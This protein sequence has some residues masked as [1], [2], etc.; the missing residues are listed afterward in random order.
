[1]AGGPTS[2]I[3]DAAGSG[4]DVDHLPFGRFAPIGHPDAL[5]RVGARIGGQVLEVA[6]ALPP[7]LRPMF[8]VGSLEPFLS[9]GPDTWA[10]V[11]SI[12]I[13]QLTDPR[14]AERLRP[15]LHSIDAVS[16]LRPVEVGDYVDFYASEHHAAALGRMFR[17]GS[18]PLLPNWKHLPV[19]YHGRAGTVVVSGTPIRRPSGQSKPPDAESPVFGPS[20]KLDIEAELGFV[21]GVGSS[22]GEPIAVADFASHVF[23]VCLVND[24]S[25]RD[26]QPWEYVPL[27]PFVAKSFATSMSGWITPLTALAAAR[28][29]PPARTHSLLP[30]LADVE[31]F[32]LDIELWIDWNGTDVG[33]PPARELYWTGAQMLAQLTVGGA[34]VRPG[35]LYA[36]GTISGPHPGT[37]GS[38]IELTR[39]GTEP[40]TLADGGSRTFLADG[41][42]VTITGTAPTATGFL[43]LGEVTGTVLPANGPPAE[44]P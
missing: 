42:T 12:L 6:A 11:R 32:G 36:S 22:Q 44:Q 34:N 8:D 38:F 30:Y 35:D 31:P 4:F 23:G 9:S 39:N 24:W 16:V 26:I 43:T 18:E 19:G 41:D 37:A 2:W 13:E 3:R 1:V 33:R 14:A 21:V 29:D 10:G 15:H 7:A 5:P 25:A 40:V 17:P 28:V 20:R 27:G